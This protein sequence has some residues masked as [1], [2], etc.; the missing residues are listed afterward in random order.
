MNFTFTPTTLPEVLLIDPRRYEDP[1]GFFMETWNARE[2]S[3][4]GLDL[5]IAQE[6]H[7]RSARRVLR[8]LHYQAEPFAMGKLVRCTAGQVFDVA[9]DL[10]VGSPRFGRWVGLDLSADN[11][12][13]LYV[14]PGFAHGFQS[15]SQFAEVQYKMTALYTPAA[16]GSLAWNDPELGIDWPLAD[17]ILSPRDAS[18]PSL[19][20]YLVSPAFRMQDEV[21]RR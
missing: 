19:R 16:E 11:R 2:F 10:R 13:L 21:A 15:L 1:R 20:E 14:P 4:A 7:S 6:G 17:P 5:V 3:A 18:A 8:G 9:V 12:R